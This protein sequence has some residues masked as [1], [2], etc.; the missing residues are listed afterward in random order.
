[1]QPVENSQFG[2]FVQLDQICFLNVGL[3]EQTKILVEWLIIDTALHSCIRLGQLSTSKVAD[4]RMREI[5]MM[6][7]TG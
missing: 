7:L 3:S 1:M 4:V 5:K 6:E 2:V